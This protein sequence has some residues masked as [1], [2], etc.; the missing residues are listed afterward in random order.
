MAKY[1]KK[2]VIIEAYQWCNETAPQWIN[3][4]Y[5]EG[6]IIYREQAGQPL[7]EI[8]TLEG[9]MIAEEH[10]YIIKGVKGEIYPCKPDI[11]ELTYEEV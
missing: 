3:D 8:Y 9:L 4:A 6:K 7:L 1:R 5:R 2:P 11:F 10:D